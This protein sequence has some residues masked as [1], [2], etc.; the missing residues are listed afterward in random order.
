MKLQKLAYQFKLL[1]NILYSDDDNDDTFFLSGKQDI[2]PS[3]SKQK[4]VTKGKET[5]KWKKLHIPAKPTSYL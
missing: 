3:G 1:G 2:M 4:K 5:V